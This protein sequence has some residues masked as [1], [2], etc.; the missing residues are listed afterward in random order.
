MEVNLKAVAPTAIPQDGYKFTKWNSPLKKI[1]SGA[2]WDSRTCGYWKSP[3]AKLRFWSVCPNPARKIACQAYACIQMAIFWNTKS[4]R[5]ICPTFG[6]WIGS[7]N[8]C[9]RCLW[10]FPRG[11][12]DLGAWGIFPRP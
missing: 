7:D 2:L 3:A 4:G 6:M 1:C 12:S 10:L 9:T 11:N 8:P 5:K